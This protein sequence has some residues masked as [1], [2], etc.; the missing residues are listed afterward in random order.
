MLVWN[1]NNMYLV[2]DGIIGAGKTSLTEKLATRTGWRMFREP[3]DPKAN[4]F[5]RSSYEVLAGNEPNRGEPLHMQLFM[6]NQRFRDHMKIAH[7]GESVI[8]DRSIWGDHIFAKVMVEDGLITKD[9]YNHLY[10]KIFE[11]LSQFLIPPS[12]ILFLKT[13]P[14]TALERIR[15]RG[16]EFERD[17]TLDYL[18]RLDE[19]Y[20]EWLQKMENYTTIYRLD[21]D[22]RELN[23]DTIDHV[24]DVIHRI[25]Q[26]NAG[27]HLL[28]R[29]T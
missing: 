22:T 1:P 17:I 28:K 5:L 7:A 2:V 25:H 12:I 23:G 8:Q 13:S 29:I 15:R 3:A 27:K 11:S 10:L 9:Q 26:S 16:R 21:Y 4:P 19:T 20:E 6:L 18:T 14:E 24:L